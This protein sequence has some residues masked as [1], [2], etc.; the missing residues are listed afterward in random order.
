MRITLTFCLSQVKVWCT[1]FTVNVGV[2]FPDPWYFCLKVFFKTC[3]C[4]HK[5]SNNIQNH[6]LAY[7]CLIYMCLCWDEQED[8][9]EV[10]DT[11]FARDCESDQEEEVLQRRSRTRKRSSTSWSS[12]CSFSTE[13]HI[14][15]RQKDTSLN[16]TLMWLSPESVFYG[17]P[18]FK[19]I[20]TEPWLV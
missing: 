11:L 14:C 8:P 10:Q 3:P 5:C 6:I 17:C 9:K 4:Y 18:P 2:R 20:E 16:F 1:W 7:G 13:Q 12:T 15:S 19:E